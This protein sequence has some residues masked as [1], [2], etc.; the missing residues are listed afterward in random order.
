M[1]GTCT[2]LLSPHDTFGSTAPLQVT[3][4]RGPL[5]HG[6]RVRALRSASRRRCRLRRR[7]GVEPQRSTCSYSDAANEVRLRAPSRCVTR[8]S[9]RRDRA[10]R[11]SRFRGQRARGRPRGDRRS[12][13][14]GVPRTGRAPL[15]LDLRVESQLSAQLAC[16]DQPV[17]NV[18]QL[19]ERRSPAPGR[20]RAGR[21]WHARRPRGHRV[22]GERPGQ[23]V[24]DANLTWARRL[25]TRLAL[26]PELAHNSNS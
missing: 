8:A 2:I 14:V 19:G 11:R 22:D 25:A 6:T 23:P 16:P 9:C 1:R 17:L 20:S 26:E 13:R 21:S 5:A 12:G 10:L 24:R 3:E 7:A 4:V 18:V 15:P